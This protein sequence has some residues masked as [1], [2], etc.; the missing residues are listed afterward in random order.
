M[1]LDTPPQ[2]SEEE[3]IRVR[4][5]NERIAHV[6]QL[7]R[8]W[9]GASAVPVQREALPAPI[10][11]DSAGWRQEFFKKSCPIVS[12]EQNCRAIAMDNDSREDVV[13]CDAQIGERK[14]TIYETARQIG[15]LVSTTPRDIS[16][17]ESL[18]EAVKEMSSCL[19][20]ELHW[21]L[22]PSSAADVSVALST[23]VYQTIWN[24]PSWDKRVDAGALDN[25]IYMLLYKRI[26]QVFG[27]ASSQWFDDEFRAYVKSH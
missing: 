22:R 20:A 2:P 14:A 8:Y 27:L 10:Q 11:A 12:T 26:S 21:Q 23:N 3:A 5:M 13:I 6:L 15:L 17:A 7:V 18:H 24:A 1:T 19:A 16:D 4:N 9:D 25:R